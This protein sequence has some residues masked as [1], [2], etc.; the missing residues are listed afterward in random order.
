MQEGA[1]S[2]D[3]ADA[4]VRSLEVKRSTYA[5]HARETAKTE[6]IQRDVWTNRQA[7]EDGERQ[8][9]FGRNAVLRGY[10]AYVLP[11]ARRLV[12]MIRD[13]RPATELDAA[14]QDFV[15]G[16]APFFAPNTARTMWTHD[17]TLFLMLKRIF[18]AAQFKKDDPKALEAS[19]LVVDSHNHVAIGACLQQALPVGHYL[20]PDELRLLKTRGF[21]ISLISPGV[22]AFWRRT[23]IAEVDARH[24]HY[25][26]MFPRPDEKVIY[27]GPRY[28]SEA[29]TKFTGAY[30][31][32][33]KKYRVKIKLGL[34]VHGDF[35]AGRL[36]EY[37]G[38][39]ADQMQH[40]E[41]IKMHLGNKSYDEF[42]REIGL[43]YGVVELN[44]NGCKRGEDPD[45]GEQYVTFKDVLLELHPEDEIRLSLCDVGSYDGVNRREWRSK[46][47]LSA[48]LGTTDGLPR[49]YRV[50]LRKTEQDKWRVEYRFQDLGR[51]FGSV[52]V[53]RR[54]HD[55]LTFPLQ[56]GKIEEYD[57]TFLKKRKNGDI[58][59]IYNENF[60]R[61]RDVNDTTYNDLKWCARVFASLPEAVVRRVLEDVHLASDLMDIYMFHISNMRNQVVGAFDLDT[62]ATNVLDHAPIAKTQLPKQKDINVGDTVKHG[63]VVGT[64][65]PGKFICPKLQQTWLMFFNQL[66]GLAGP[67][68]VP[69]FSKQVT[70]IYSTAIPN[71]V[72]S[73]THT[74]TDTFFNNVI[75]PEVGKFSLSPGIMVRVGRSVGASAQ[76]LNAEGKGNLFVVTDSLNF[77][78]GVDSPFFKTVLSLLPLAVR[79]KL[80]VLNWSVQHLHFAD[81]CLGGLVSAPR[82]QKAVMG[83]PERFALLDLKPSEV[84]RN[85]WSFGLDM[86]LSVDLNGVDPFSALSVPFLNTGVGV[87]LGWISNSDLTF[88]KN[89]W[90]GLHL[91]R[92]SGQQAFGS[93]GGQVMNAQLVLLQSALLGLQK[94]QSSL[95]HE[96]WEIEITPPKYDQESARHALTENVD[97]DALVNQIKR[98]RHHPE[99]VTSEATA[100]SLPDNFHLRYHS[101]ATENS[102][103][104]RASALFF[105]N[106]DR[107]DQ[108]VD[109]NIESETAQ[110]EFIHLTRAKRAFTGYEMMVNGT[111]NVAM[112]QGTSKKV[113][114]EMDRDN[115]RNFVAIIDVY[116]YHLS[117]KHSDVLALITRLNR[118][119]AKDAETPFFSSDIPHVDNR[120]R[121]VY[122]NGRI[123]VNGGK[124]LS[125]VESLSSEALEALVRG[126]YASEATQDNASR[127]PSSLESGDRHRICRAAV[128]WGRAVAVAAAGL[129]G[130]QHGA[131][132][133]KELAGKVAQDYLATVAGTFVYA[134]YQSKYGA[135]LLKQIFGE[136]G[137][138][139]QAEI[140]GIYQQTGMLSNDMW[141]NDM[142]YCGESWG[143]LSKPAPIAHWIRYDQK[144]PR[145]V[146]APPRVAWETLLGMQV[147]GRP[148]NIVG[149]GQ[150]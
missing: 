51:S 97:V 134:L 74:V 26:P 101:K 23:T 85:T 94:S 42:E 24:A 34:E 58:A 44:G 78:I 103:T 38:Y 12:D 32:D 15:R 125:V 121:K 118:R 105:L 108:R 53:I 57:R 98:V 63:K 123:Y 126:A 82:I 132:S 119:Y 48:C 91:V 20:S 135:R 129:A 50:V 61:N 113:S 81:N 19:N 100:P 89:V 37:M 120:Y 80:Q 92:E 18:F 7:E 148:G 90:G 150:R 29:T 93:F 66:F 6:R 77:S 33:G 122:A 60:R 75:P 65:Y 137:V 2:L 128:K 138:L 49:N 104:A 95:A 5:L 144:M 43:K 17:T 4:F 72:V 96:C 83:D 68:S 141:Q 46:D 99:L 88:Y 13:G 69:S 3:K 10:D 36:R 30:L 41:E 87:G 109:I 25:A 140:F 127:F 40:R 8:G 45:T 111:N 16:Y 73:N 147:S 76:L 115:P 11:H 84:L 35:I 39:S 67:L 86:G 102:N 55:L 130:H 21:D 79:A 70:D 149:L 47:L 54:L 31:R 117:L 146:Y 107:R 71:R 59:L 136:D 116:D 56:Y 1:F 9:V 106:Y 110:H 112:P 22:S 114:L 143:R 142:R 64:Y 124:L 52:P 14:A 139:V 145:N 133:A 28:R 27:D 62:N 131:K